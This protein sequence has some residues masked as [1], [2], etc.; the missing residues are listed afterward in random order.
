MFA[1]TEGERTGSPDG[2]LVE[3]LCPRST[4]L[5][6]PCPPG[7]AMAQFNRGSTATDGNVA[8]LNNVNVPPTLCTNVGTPFVKSTTSA[9]LLCCT[10]TNPRWVRGLIPMAHGTGAGFGAVF[11]LG[12]FSVVT[13][14]VVKLMTEIVLSAL[15]VTAAMWSGN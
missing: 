4:I 5:M 14:S 7:V 1:S 12:K 13:A 9:V 3:G 10:A 8:V 6:I 11:G 2:S 15:F